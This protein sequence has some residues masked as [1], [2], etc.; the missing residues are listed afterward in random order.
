[1]AKQK[2]Q[3]PRIVMHSLPD[4]VRLAIISAKNS[5]RNR[6][7]GRGTAF[8]NSPAVLP[9]LDD[10][11]EYFEFDVGAAR[12]GDPLGQRGKRRLVIEVV[13]KPRQVRAIYFTDQHYTS[14]SFRLVV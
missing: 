2:A 8:S 13:T 12:S 7:P 1:M 6:L 10:G 3:I 5:I 14:G 4:D 11:C 9:N